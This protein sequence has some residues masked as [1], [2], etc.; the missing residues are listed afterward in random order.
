VVHSERRACLPAPIDIAGHPEIAQV[1]EKCGIEQQLA[2]IAALR[3]DVRDLVLRE[4]KIADKINYRSEPARDREFS[5][6]RILAKD[7]VKCRFVIA[8][9]GFPITTCHSYL[10]KVDRQSREAVRGRI[11]G[12]VCNLDSPRDDA[13]LW[14]ARVLT[15]S[16]RRRRRNAHLK[17]ATDAFIKKC[18]ARHV[19]SP[20]QPINHRAA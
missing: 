12:P 7:D 4:T 20:D 2:I 13:N 10:V 15:C 5:T 8:H 6:E 3:R 9:A 1:F 11:H 18:S 19:R 16:F 17:V 14:G